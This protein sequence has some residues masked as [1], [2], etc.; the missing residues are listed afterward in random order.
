MGLASL[1]CV[2]GISVFCIFV[3]IVWIGEPRGF[4]GNWDILGPVLWI[5]AGLGVGW[6]A[7]NIK[8]KLDKEVRAERDEKAELENQ[9]KL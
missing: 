3:G 1:V 8:L 7:R 6:K 9:V 2:G 5:S 4:K